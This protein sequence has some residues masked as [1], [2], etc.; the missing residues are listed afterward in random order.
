MSATA[1]SFGSVLVGSGFWPGLGVGWL[2]G[3]P[4]DS[5]TRQDAGIAGC[6]ASPVPSQDLQPNTLRPV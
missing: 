1:G 6:T 5:H 3:M 4:P 2:V